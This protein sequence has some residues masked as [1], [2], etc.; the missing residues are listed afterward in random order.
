MIDSSRLHVKAGMA[1]LL[2]AALLTG[3]DAATTSIAQ[4]M[5]ESRDRAEYA[6]IAAQGNPQFSDPRLQEKVRA[7][8]AEYAVYGR[9]AEK[10]QADATAHCPVTPAEAYRLLRGVGH[11]EQQDAPMRYETGIDETSVIDL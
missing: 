2:C 10:L 8:E 5:T 9:D 6:R 7:F 3:C 1:A 11:D 4:S